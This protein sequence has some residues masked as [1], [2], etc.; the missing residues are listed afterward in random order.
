[1]SKDKLRRCLNGCGGQVSLQGLAVYHDW[2]WGESY[3]K[4]GAELQK[5]EWIKENIK[6]PEHYDSVSAMLIDW[7]LY[8]GGWFINSYNN[9]HLFNYLCQIG[10][11]YE[12]EVLAHLK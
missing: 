9:T 7:Q 10:S 1:M 3:D 12:P 5:N 6:S 8:E 4:L 2:S 11:N